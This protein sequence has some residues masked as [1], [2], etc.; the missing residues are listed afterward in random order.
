M[1][2]KSISFIAGI[3]LAVSSEA[4]AQDMNWSY[5]NGVSSDKATVPQFAE[6]KPIATPVTQEQKQPVKQEIIDVSFSD[7][8]NIN[9]FYRSGNYEEEIDIKPIPKPVERKVVKTEI[10]KNETPLKA[11][12]ADSVALSGQITAIKT[13]RPQQPIARGTL[14]PTQV[15]N[16]AL[17]EN[18]K[19]AQTQ[20]TVKVQYPITKQYPVSVQYPVSIQRDVTVQQ[21][22]VVQQPVIVKKPVIMQQPVMLQR[23]T[24]F[25]QQQPLVMQQQPTYI[26][27]QPVVMQVS[28]PA[29]LQQPI[30]LNQ[31]PAF[32]PQMQTT[33][34][35]SFQ[36]AYQPQMPVSSMPL[37]GTSQFSYTAAP[38]QFSAYPQPQMPVQQI[39]PQQPLIYGY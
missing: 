10:I 23:Q 19:L 35:M 30:M 14:A 32:V 29:P 5:V 8:D 7:E 33:P 39:I 12:T 2:K 18:M 34:V 1:I 25:I 11:T 37:S 20:D 21:P 4:M 27:K 36:P 31:Q 16:E 15:A 9:N 17:M 3:F 6:S 28:T 13:A 38:A 24:A 26:Q 22:V